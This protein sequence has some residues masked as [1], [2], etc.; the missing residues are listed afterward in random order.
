MRGI[1]SLTLVIADEVPATMPKINDDDASNPF[2]SCED[3]DPEQTVRGTLLV[4]LQVP[5]FQCLLALLI[6]QTVLI[7]LPI[8]L[9]SGKYLLEASAASRFPA[10]QLCEGGFH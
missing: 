8:V 7:H 10:R 3:N 9:V 4:R 2:A 1:P 6:C 5:P